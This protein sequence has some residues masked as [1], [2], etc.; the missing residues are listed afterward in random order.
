MQ[1]HRRRPDPR[2]GAAKARSQGDQIRPNRARQETLSKI[3]KR[4][5]ESKSVQIPEPADQ[6]G[7]RDGSIHMAR[8]LL[9]LRLN[10]GADKC[11]KADGP[12]GQ[13][14]SE[15]ESTRFFPEPWSL[16]RLSPRPWYP[17]GGVCR[18]K[19]HGQQIS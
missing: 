19:D 15:D 18:T 14:A 13:V 6:E 5:R 17:N 16:V 3:S 9:P 10:A 11:S 12:T 4:L 2:L 8:H 1:K 7:R